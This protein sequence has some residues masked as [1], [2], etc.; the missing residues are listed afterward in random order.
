M[1]IKE[2]LQKV[3]D[4]EIDV[5]E[6]LSKIND[7]NAVETSGKFKVKKI[8]KDEVKDLIREKRKSEKK[9][10][11]GFQHEGSWLTLNLEFGA[12]EIEDGDT[13]RI[14]G[15]CEKDYDEE[16]HVLKLKKGKE[17]SIYIPYSVKNLKIIS[18]GSSVDIDISSKEYVELDVSKSSVEG[19]IDAEE[20]RISNSLGSTELEITGC[21]KGVL[22][23]KLGNVEIE[24][25]GKYNFDVSNTLGSVDID[26]DL[27][28]E[29]GGIIKVKN[30]LGNVEF[31][32][33]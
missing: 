20:F 27:I 5:E 25:S 14:E 12:Y 8:S 4:G 26:E 22:E 18:R 28:S 9:E 29:E 11:R 3:K 23:N 1:D 24:L 17:C 33:S 6:A 7:L 15:I 13:F 16:K 21:K 32:E 30:Q 31:H 2:I 19:E 10:D